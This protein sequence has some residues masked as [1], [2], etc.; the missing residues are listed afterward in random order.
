MQSEV[1]LKSLKEAVYYLGRRRGLRM[2]Q[3]VEGTLEKHKGSTDD[4]MDEPS[5]KSDFLCTKTEGEALPKKKK[6]IAKKKKK[7]IK[8]TEEENE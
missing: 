3:G 8:K 7:T 2:S 5:G 6:K 4:S 1:A